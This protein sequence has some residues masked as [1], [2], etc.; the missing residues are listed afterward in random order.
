MRQ[1][2]F[3]ISLTLLLTMVSCEDE[4][5]SCEDSFLSD[6]NNLQ[7]QFTS[8]YNA[9]TTESDFTILKNSITSFTG[10]YPEKCKVK[11]VVYDVNEQLEQFVNNS[12]VKSIITP[13]VIYGKDD[14][15]E[16]HDSPD[17]RHGKWS[18]AVAVQLS[19][20]KIGPNGEIISDTIQDTMSLCPTEEFSNQMNPG[21]CS[22]F[23][24][25]KN[26]LVTAGHCVE[27]Q[28]DCSNYKWA[29][30]F[31]AGITSLDESQIYSCTKIISQQLSSSTQADFAVI[32]LDRVV[33]N[34][35]PLTFR[36]EGNVSSGDPLTVMGHPSGLPM[37]VAAG[38][39]VRSTTADWFFTANL[40]TFGGN[41]G[42]P[43]FNTDTGIVEG[44]LVRG[45]TDYTWSR[46]NDGNSCRVVFQCEDD[47]CR[48]EDVTRITKVTGLPKEETA[49][50]ILSEFFTNSTHPLESEG[51]YFK[52]NVKRE[53]NKY[54]AGIK[55]L[56]LC[57]LHTASNE[58]SFNW[59]DS[60]VTNCKTGE[61]A[62][63]QVIET[64]KK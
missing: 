29:F 36:K 46:D 60:T 40:D 54:L 44:I 15:L 30:G 53:A 13:K 38:A 58:D 57:A 55:F 26:T 48:G 51:I 1:L 32:E 22:G 10:K 42:S 34:A 33:V 18:S 28:A 62:L 5:T 31:K 39:K 6:Y 52:V 37:K 50:E 45:E 21:R 7:S 49:K 11:D 24:V 63:L 47:E 56:D 19:S 35:T 64:F 23:L 61:G 25:G 43:V 9:S 59:I 14:R 20:S 41:S 12:S 17:Q 27:D 4:V 3:I 8:I 2:N 16:I